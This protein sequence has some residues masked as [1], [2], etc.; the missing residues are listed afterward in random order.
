[1]AFDFM[2]IKYPEIVKYK[3]H[4]KTLISSF[5]EL[6]S[7]EL[8]NVDIIVASFSVPFCKPEYFKN[9]GVIL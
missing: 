7:H 5:E 4:F 6:D 8:P 9:F 2:L 1:M 3:D